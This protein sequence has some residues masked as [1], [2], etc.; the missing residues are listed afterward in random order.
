MSLIESKANET[1]TEGREG[2]CR[3]GAEAKK[4]TCKAR[5]AVRLDVRTS[6]IKCAKEP[7]KEAAARRIWR[8]A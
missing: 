5:T 6:C 1:A 4:L 8:C 3:K 7:L 2:P